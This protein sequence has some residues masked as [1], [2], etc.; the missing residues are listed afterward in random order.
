MKKELIDTIVLKGKNMFNVRNDSKFK[1]IYDKYSSSLLDESRKI[2]GEWFKSNP[3]KRNVSSS[4]TIEICRSVE[5]DD[6]I[7]ADVVDELHRIGVIDDELINITFKSNDYDD[8]I[9]ETTTYN[10]KC[11]TYKQF[12]DGI[13]V[14]E[15]NSRTFKEFIF[16]NSRYDN[17][18]NHFPAKD[19]DILRRGLY[20]C[21]KD[22][23]VDV[24]KYLPTNTSSKYPLLPKYRIVM[25]T[26]FDESK[27]KKFYEELKSDRRLQRFAEVH[28]AVGKGINNYYAS[29]GPG[30]Y[31]G[32]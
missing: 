25:R 15:H 8:R 20:D 7:F 9:F 26:I 30:D 16:V 11:P 29:K 28:D 13:F 17:G 18:Y 19:I 10:F 2:F 31:V 4:S 21:V 32:D 14:E 22:I 5:C 23:K 12:R 24:F 3:N 6:K 27:L 1:E